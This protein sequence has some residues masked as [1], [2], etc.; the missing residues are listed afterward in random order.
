MKRQAPKFTPAIV[1]KRKRVKGGEILTINSPGGPTKEK[2]WADK[3]K[4]KRV[5]KLSRE[6][7]K[8]TKLSPDQLERVKGQAGEG[9]ASRYDNE[10]NLSLPLARKLAKAKAKAK[11]F[12]LYSDQLGRRLYLSGDT[13]GVPLT[14]DKREALRFI[15]GFDDPKI[16]KEYWERMFSLYEPG[17]LLSN[18]KLKTTHP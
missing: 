8:Y 18:V 14:F 5:K 4:E 1:I 12:V 7:A 11:R 9:L 16:K 17:S 15:E 10:G 2:V 13:K 3:A 6:L